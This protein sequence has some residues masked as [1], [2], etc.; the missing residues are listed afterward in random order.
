[1]ATR[2]RTEYFLSR[3]GSYVG[4]MKRAR[5]TDPEGRLLNDPDVETG[6][7]SKLP[8]DWLAKVDDINYDV[9]R[10]GTKMQQLTENHQKHL[11]PTIGGDEGEDHER[12]IEVLTAE[13]TRLF[14]SIKTKITNLSKNAGLEGEE[15]K[16]SKHIQQKLALEL[17]E[18]SQQ[19]KDL[20]KDYLNKLRG[21]QGGSD[22]FDFE[23]E[24]IMDKGFS[25]AQKQAVATS[26]RLVYEREQEMRNVL[27]SIVEL[28]E[29]FKDLSMLIVD[30]GTILDRIDYNLEQT[31]HHV[32]KAVENLTQASESQKAARMKMCIYLLL[33]LVV[34]MVL[35]VILRGT[36]WGGSSSTTPTTVTNTSDSGWFRR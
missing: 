6:E 18:K 36:I 9:A 27:Q 14:H 20:Q 1:M 4:H 28:S 16:M 2:N 19:F 3:R 13:I 34:L 17:Q 29:I 11:L 32:E 5:L 15:E 8:P 21:R 24:D 22:R 30:Q 25:D 7:I 10:I 33:V 26:E 23:V 35:L 31:E 12:K